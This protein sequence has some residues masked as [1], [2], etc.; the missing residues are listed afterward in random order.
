[1]NNYHFRFFLLVFLWY[2]NSILYANSLGTKDNYGPLNGNGMNFI[3]NKG[4]LVDMNNNLR[5]DIL[6]AGDGGGMQVYLRKTGIS[7][8]LSNMTE[9]M[10]EV[11]REIEES[12]RRGELLNGGKL[13]KEQELLSKKMLKL[14]RID[15]EFEGGDP[16]P[17]VLSSDKVDGYLNYYYGHCTGGITNVQS[18]NR[19][20]YQNVYPNIDI[21]FY[22]G[23]KDGLKYDIIVR[24]GGDPNDIK[25]KYSGV[26]E[27]KVESSKLRVLSSLG[28]LTEDLPR[29]YQNINGKIVDVKAEYQLQGT[30]LNL[31][32]STYNLQHP[33]VI[34]PWATYYGGSAFMGDASIDITTDVLGNVVIA[35]ATSSS[36]FPV[37]VG[38]FQ[39]S[40]GGSVDAFVIKFNSAGTRQWATYYGGNFTDYGNGIATDNLGNIVI[41]GQT[42]SPT[43]PITSGAFQTNYRG[44]AG[45]EDAFLV[46]FDAAGAR[47]WATFYGGNDDDVAT[48]VATDTSGNVIFTGRTS[49][50]NFPVTLGAFQT[51]N[52]GAQSAFVVKF[53]GLGVRQWATY[54]G[55][56]SGDLGYSIATD[57]V[58]NTY[59]T[60]LTQSSDFP[61]T[62]GVF[63]TVLN[64]IQDAFVAKLDPL[65]VPIWS[66]FYGGNDLEWGEDIALDMLGNVVISGETTSPSFP[67]TPGAFQTVYGGTGTFGGDAF[68]VKFNPTGTL[69][70]ATFYGG[71]HGDLGFDITTDKKNNIYLGMEEE[72]ITTPPSLAA[73]A[74]A[75]Q[76]VFNG[77]EDQII[78]KFTPNGQKICATFLGGTGEDDI[79]A[80]GIVI[81]DNSLYI[82]GSTSGGYPVTAGAFQTV[83]GGGTFDAF[84]ASLCTNICEG[85]TL[86]LNY[87]VGGTSACANTPVM[88]SSVI[89]NSCDTS[90]YQYQWTFQGGSPASSSAMDPSVTYV[91]PGTYPVTLVLTTLCKKDTV[92]NS[93]VI[94]S[95]T[96]AVINPV[97]CNSH[98]VNGQ[99][100]TTSGLYTQ[101]LYTVSG[102]DSILTINLTINSDLTT[103]SN[104]NICEG[105]SASI[106][107]TNQTV[108]G[109]YS[110]T[111]FTTGGCDS[112][113]VISL[114]VFPNPLIDLGNDITI[115]AGQQ[116]TLSVS[117]AS[118]NTYQWSTGETSIT[119]N[120]KPETATIYSAI[121]TD[122]NGCTATDS[123]TVNVISACDDNTEAF[124]PNSFS[125]NGDGENDQLQLYSTGNPASVYFAVYNRWGE[126]VFEAN[127]LNEAWDGTYRSKPLDVA[128]YTYILKITCKGILGEK[129]KKGNISLLR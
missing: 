105:E 84:I 114:S 11:K 49:S 96:G 110:Q 20:V 22:G 33:L 113:S 17:V 67:V 26:D 48:S 5:S 9:V 87:T 19:I 90:G 81:V 21:V 38:A 112:V 91:A 10:K 65:G 100:Y 69:Q 36:N 16:S 32:L 18:Y 42:N 64:G 93:V 68:V 122:V 12:E 7:Y 104:E 111:L 128:V 15:M 24:P 71:I 119:I 6:Y 126:I 102:C 125:P 74:C 31:Q 34:D 58:G 14:H 39:T 1:M 76:P 13:E 46:K 117:A 103:T 35:G 37:S 118:G 123:I 72:D 109:I 30:T 115:T 129:M 44:S 23:K 52:A 83:Y 4:Q 51:S 127:G 43:F 107:G 75:L 63:Q 120:A 116:A 60:G 79:D 40:G 89:N 41:A 80:G 95:D 86:G 101:T 97:A 59:I 54:Y 73:D 66:G 108:A 85:K 106:H 47:Q 3:E 8:V 99:T 62:A 25:L 56:S 94:N 55:G 53:D 27:I 77:V 92:S 45:L 61:Y 28:E 121:I 70:W 88:F 29:V 82:T 78:V 98:T 50:T 124:V 57:I 2:G